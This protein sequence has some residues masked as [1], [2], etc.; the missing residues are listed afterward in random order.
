MRLAKPETPKP[1]A[2]VTP[3]SASQIQIVIYCSKKSDLE[4]RIRSGGHS[5]EGLSYVS[6]VPFVL[7]DM[8]NIR[9]FSFDPKSKTAWVESGLTN[10]ELYYRIGQATKTLGF[11]SGLWAN[12]GIGGI[13]SG[14]GYG[15]MRRKYGLA[16]DNVIDAKLIDVHGRILDRKSMGEDLF[17][18]IR[19][20]GGGSF[21]VVLSWKIKLVPVPK[22]VTVFKVTRTVEQNLTNTFNRWQ[23]VVTKFPKELDIRCTGQSIL[24]DASPRDDKRTMVM[25]F[26]SLYLG[27]KDE[28]LSVMQERFPELGL[29]RED[30]FE[31]SW[32]QAMMFFS[33][34]E[35]DMPPEILLDRTILPKPAFKGRSD[36]TEVPIPEKGV[37]G[38][39]EMMYKIEPK[40]AT[41]QFTPFGGRMDE[42]SESAL[43][44]PYR[45]G[46]LY[47]MNMFAVTEINEAERIEWV[48]SLERYLTPYVTKSP[49]SAYVN[50]VNLWMGTNNPHGRTS[51][52][53]ASKWGKRYFKNNFDKLVKVKSKVDPDNF[54]K[55]EQ[56]I[57]V[58]SY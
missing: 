20:G 32:V 5:F 12:V 42:I 51:Y 22:I 38:L 17:W 9:S 45:A 13:I 11:P 26:E 15:M 29:A 49:R 25:L 36:F 47:M 10:G 33:N 39:W 53:Q 23:S 16:A 2:I 35:V 30:C 14:G 31:V 46:T 37:Q 19:G 34:F 7:L 55:H 56:S 40:A 3:V 52:Q 6:Q 21:G 44:F 48:R 18:A 1:L 27:G 28:L 24:S 58:I 57:P 41:L 43:P 4:I 54:F 8:V 50:Y